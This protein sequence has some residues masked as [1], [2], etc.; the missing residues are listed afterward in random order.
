MGSNIKEET[1]TYKVDGVSYKAFVAYDQDIKGKR[2]VVLVVHEWWGL[3]D[4]PK[5]RARQLAGLGYLAMAVDLFGDG[6]IARD[7][8]EAREF[9]APFYKDP[10][11]F[12]TRMDAAFKKI[13][14][15][16]E[17][18]QANMAAIGYCFGGSA[19]LNFAKLGGDVNAVVSF[20]G[21]FG[22][23]PPDKKLLKARI[24][25]C[26]GAADKFV[27]L[28]DVSTFKHQIES[29]HSDCIVRIYPGATHAFTNPDATEIGKKFNLPIEYNAAADKESWDDMISF[30]NRI[31]R[32]T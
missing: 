12:K 28:K 20:H 2:P 15:Y 8:E 30:F 6:K 10:G 18:D 14:E 7:P 22:G 31:L 1:L 16:P 9:T 11:L 24:L 25:V 17:A 19:V 29:I 26:H 4:Y 27:S 13:R 32:K 5:M 21:S 3:N 23:A